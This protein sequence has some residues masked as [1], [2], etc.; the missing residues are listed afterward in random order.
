MKTV[1][2][3]VL[4]ARGNNSDTDDNAVIDRYTVEVNNDGSFDEKSLE[5]QTNKYL[6]NESKKEKGGLKPSVMACS[7]PKL[8]KQFQQN[9][10]TKSAKRKTL[11]A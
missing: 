1:E 2:F 4:Y 6:D 11:K 3:L 10:T 7:D 8:K 5:Q 9:I